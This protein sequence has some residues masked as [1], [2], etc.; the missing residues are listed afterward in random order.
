MRPR[1][2]AA[3]P[4]HDGRVATDDGPEEPD[5]PDDAARSRG[6]FAWAIGLV[7]LANVAVVLSGPT[8][9]GGTVVILAFFVTLVAVAVLSGVLRR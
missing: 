6:R 5:E 2:R 1:A 7:V 4:C 8:S 9:Q 3:A